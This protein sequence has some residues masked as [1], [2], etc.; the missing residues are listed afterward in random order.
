MA[1]ILE[2]EK[3]N[4][5]HADAGVDDAGQGIISVIAE[6]EDRRQ[7]ERLIDKIRRIDGISSVE[8]VSPTRFA[9][10]AR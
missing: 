4:I 6:V 2:K 8:R 10:P 9:G 1:E 7:V 3:I 5:R